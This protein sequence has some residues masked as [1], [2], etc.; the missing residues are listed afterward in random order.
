MIHSN[1]QFGFQETSLI[2][3]SFYGNWDIFSGFFDEYK[4][5]N[6]IYL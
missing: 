5:Q 6:S 3:L 4:I 2:V 1:I